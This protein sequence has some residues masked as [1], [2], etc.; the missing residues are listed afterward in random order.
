M[1]TIEKL[2]MC[3]KEIDCMTQEEAKSIVKQMKFSQDLNFQDENLN[4]DFCILFSDEIYGKDDKVD[5]GIENYINKISK[6]TLENRFDSIS[7]GYFCINYEIE[8]T[9]NLCSDMYK[10]DITNGLYQK[11]DIN[12]Y[13]LEAA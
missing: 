9:V 5:N 10:D 6:R 3:I 11:K 2:K 4:S 8:D 12:N 13:D 7:E 1:N